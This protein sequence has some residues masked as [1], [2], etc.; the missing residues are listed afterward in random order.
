VPGL[1][2]FTEREIREEVRQLIA[3]G[4]GKD[5]VAV[6]PE[7]ERGSVDLRVALRL[8]AAAES[9]AIAVKAAANGAGLRERLN[10]LGDFVVRPEALVVGPV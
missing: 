5:G 2:H 10:V 4:E 8:L 7:D 9:G 6:A 3:P 1:L